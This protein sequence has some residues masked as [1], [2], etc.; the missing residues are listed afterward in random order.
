MKITEFKQKK[1]WDTFIDL[2]KLMK[3]FNQNEKNKKKY[4]ALKKADKTSSFEFMKI[5]K[6]IIW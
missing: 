6:D 3:E 5:K 4:F 1:Y 2:T